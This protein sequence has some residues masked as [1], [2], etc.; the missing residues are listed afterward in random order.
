M[1]RF[2][3]AVLIQAVHDF[4][5]VETRDLGSRYW[6]EFFKSERFEELCLFSD[7]DIGWMLKIF[8]SISSVS[9]EI[10]PEITSDVVRLMKKVP[11]PEGV[12]P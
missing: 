12:T 6:D 11:L 1:I 7:F 9:P 10:R 5:S 8:R 4:G 2:Y 3:R